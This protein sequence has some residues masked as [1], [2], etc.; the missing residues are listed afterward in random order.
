VSIAAGGWEPVAPSAVAYDNGYTTPHALTVE[1]IAGVVAAF[2]NSAQRALAAG[3]QIVEIH[4]AHGYLIHQFLSPLSNKRDDQYGGSF[5][6]RIRL[7][8]EVAKAV[9]EVWPANLPLFCRVSATDWADGGWD[10]AET[11]ELSKRLKPLG[12]DLIDTSSAGL[13]P[14]QKIA[15]GFGY[16]VPFAEAIRKQADILTGAVGMI[17]DGAQADTILTTGQADLI[18]LARE[19]LRDPYWPRRAAQELHAKIEPPVQYQRAW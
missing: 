1:E 17:T 9:R 3:F 12:V 11:V 10:I 15:I 16:Q 4:A 19:F 14:F 8:L 7:A 5:E 18:F 2:R 6:N 13:V